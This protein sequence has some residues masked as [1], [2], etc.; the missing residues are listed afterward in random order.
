M[1]PKRGFMGRWQSLA[2]DQSGVSAVIAAIVIV[3]VI[4]FAALALDVGHLV[5]VKAELQKASEAGALAGARAL[6][7]S[8]DGT[9]IVTDW[10]WQ[11]G[12]DKAV[13]MVQQ[14]FADTLSLADFTVDNV[15]AGFWDLNWTQA[16]APVHLLGYTNPAAFVPS[17]NQVAAVKVTIAKSKGGSGSSA[18][19]VASFASVW[20]INS[21]EAKASAVAMISP[22]TTIPYSSAW[23]FALPWTWVEQHWDDKPPLSFGVAANQHVDSGGQWTSF[24]S[25][26]NGATYINGLIL[27][28]DTSDSISLGDN[29]FIQT[30]ERASIYNTVLDNCVGQ[31]RYIPVVPDNF[32]NNDF[33]PVLAYVPFQVTE[34]IGSG[35]DPTVIGHFR[36]GWVDPNARGSGGKYFGDPLPPRLVN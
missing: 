24:K 18:P 31:T 26:E 16:T 29:I 7:L 14:N 32:P 25:Q 4:G 19:V 28:T 3:V 17:N 27:G 23:P 22:P 5:D 1:K 20:G 6:A 2:A 34:V 8:M 33:S 36:P 21:M 12:K 30:G 10:Q 11:N 15:E 13:S 9:E 35:K